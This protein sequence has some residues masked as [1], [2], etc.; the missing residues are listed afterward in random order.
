MYYSS[1]SPKLVD[2]S[3][4]QYSQ[5][6]FYAGENVLF[7]RDIL[8][9]IDT[10]VITT[11]TWSSP[12]AR[13]NIPD[14]TSRSDSRQLVN[15]FRNGK[16]VV[17]VGIDPG[18]VETV[19]GAKGRWDKGTRKFHPTLDSG[20]GPGASCIHSGLLS[21]SRK[22]KRLAWERKK[23]F[24]AEFEW[25]SLITS[26]IFARQA[27]LISKCVQVSFAINGTLGHLLAI[28]QSGQ[29]C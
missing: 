29:G 7:K 4:S 18:K 26:Q 17:V 19:T 3:Y 27:E 1:R 24:R 6:D 2:Y 25:A 9:M 8:A 28:I 21:H 14:I 12:G 10:K 23:A 11:D 5:V 20:I 13:V 16:N 15:D 22:M